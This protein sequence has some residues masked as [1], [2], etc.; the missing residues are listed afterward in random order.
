MD[1]LP[2]FET[3]RVDNQPP[4]FEPRDLWADDVVL[5]E[6]VLREGGEAFVS[7]LAAYGALAG[8]ELYRLGFDANRDRPRLRTHDRLGHRIDT[9][10]FHPA[11]H[12]LMEVAKTHGVAGLSWHEPVPGA[13]VARAA[14]SYLHHQAEAGTSCPLTMTHAAVPVLQRIPALREW[15]AKAAAPHYDPRD[16]PIADKAGITLGMGMTEKQGGSDVRANA[17]VATAQAD[18]TY[19]LVGHKWFFSAPMCDG[20][21]VLAQAPGGLTCLLMP[22]RR[23]DGTKNAFRLMRLK[24]K[25]GDWA[26]ASSEVEFTGAQAWRVGEEGRGVATIIEMVMLTRL[27][28]M[29]GSA[30]EMRMA[31]AQAVHHAR[32][33]R[34]FGQRLVDHALMQ[35]VLA[36]LALESEAATAFAVRVARAVDAAPRDTAEAAFARVATAVGKFWI[37]KCAPAF[38]NE[39][40]ECLGGAGYVEESILPRL[41]RQAPLNSIWEGSGNVQCL[42][43]LR[44]LSREPASAQAVLAELEACAGRDAIFDAFV[45]RLQHDMAQATESGA[46]RLVERLA[47]ALQAGVLI[48]AGSP[49]AEMFVRSRLGGEQGRV[50]GT[51][52]EGDFAGVIAR[53][54]PA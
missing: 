15:A 1:D 30:A 21:L 4:A 48:R 35:N 16:V 40:Q 31:L 51:L 10:E 9:V 17:T 41:Y 18:G 22:R 24:D 8:D 5:R 34:A 49:V 23:E 43:V 13:H 32:H 19:A 12:R 33:R 25:L 38:V 11:Y 3:H 20:F 52:A 37:C 44:A 39:A 28:C 14:L 29:L 7:R 26:N 50:F 6:A 27:D 53:T 46:R 2:P 36:D 54:L 45:G 47:L 42:D